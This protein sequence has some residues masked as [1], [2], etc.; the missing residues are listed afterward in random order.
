MTR[1][2]IDDNTE[3]IV[4]AVIEGMQE[5]KGENIVVLNL[6]DI[7]NSICD[8]FIICHGTSNTQVEA[9]ADSV[10]EIV[11]NKVNEKVSQKEGLENAQWILLDYFTV[12]VHV[13]QKEYRDFYNL[14]NLWA[15]AKISF[16]KS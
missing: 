3:L 7:Q 11:R 15:D 14:E 4:D 9:I 16:I 8:Y 10:E 2:R 13:F 6:K 1:K 12:I 5:K